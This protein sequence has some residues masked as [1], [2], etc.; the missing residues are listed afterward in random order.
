M[1]V[2]RIDLP[3]HSKAVQLS[4][5]IRLCRAAVRCCTWKTNFQSS[6]SPLQCCFLC[7]IPN[8]WCDTS[9]EAAL[10]PAI[11]WCWEEECLPLRSAVAITHRDWILGKLKSCAFNSD[12]WNTQLDTQDSSFLPLTLFLSANLAE[13]WTPVPYCH[14]DGPIAC[15]CSELIRSSLWLFLSGDG[16]L[17]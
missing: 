5:H 16:N 14:T 13:L 2:P 8:S 7:A 1:F 9:P 12:V 3:T 15:W 10:M 11:R 4:L 6:T 17:H